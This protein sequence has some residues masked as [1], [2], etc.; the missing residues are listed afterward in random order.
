MEKLQ[1]SR[2]CVCVRTLRS[3]FNSFFLFFWLKR[4]ANVLWSDKPLWESEGDFVAQDE[5]GGGFWTRIKSLRM[6][7]GAGRS[8]I[9]AAPGRPLNSPTYPGVPQAV[10]MTFP[11]PS[12]F[13]RPK[14]LIMIFDS[15]WALKYSKFSGWTHKQ[16]GV[17]YR[18]LFRESK[19]QH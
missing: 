6:I 1:V 2:W 10:D 16:R 3:G 5:P 9:G 18:F 15:S 4:S 14:S 12:I 7:N 19:T 13:E 8:V 17:N 11:A